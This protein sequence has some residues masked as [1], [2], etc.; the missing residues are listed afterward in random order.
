MDL[1][2]IP[3]GR[4][5]PYHN[6]LQGEPNRR[7][8]QFVENGGSFLGICAGG[9]YGS[10]RVVFEEG[11]ELEVVAH[12]ELAFFP[13]RAIGP[14]YGKNL[15]SYGNQSGA[16]EAPIRWQEGVCGLYF[17]GG[18]FFEAPEVYEAVE[19]LATYDDLEGSPAAIVSC[20]VGQGRA[21]LSGVHFECSVKGGQ[22]AARKQLIANLLGQ[23]Q[24]N[25]H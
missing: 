12:R 22:E 11:G 23:L 6:H 1:L 7:M 21:I 16:R 2:V 5:V 8:R 10:G 14:A 4:D 17:N 15:F 18:C 3:G 19:V 24:T 25:N 13:G 20:Q 9:Y